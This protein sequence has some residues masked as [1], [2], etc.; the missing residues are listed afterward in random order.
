MNTPTSGE[1]RQRPTD[2]A[3]CR[4]E[5]ARRSMLQAEARHVAATA[6][7]SAAQALVDEELAEFHDQGH[8]GGSDVRSD[9]PCR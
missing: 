5:F 2:C 4:P 7:A 9:A 8:N 1:I 3:A 6:G